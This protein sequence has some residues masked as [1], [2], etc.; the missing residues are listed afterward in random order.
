LQELLKKETDQKTG[1]IKD[2][3]FKMHPKEIIWNGA[4]WIAAPQDRNK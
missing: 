2:D 3:N 4:N 1:L